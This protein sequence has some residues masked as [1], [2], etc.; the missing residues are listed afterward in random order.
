MHRNF[1][2]IIVPQQRNDN[3]LTARITVTTWDPH[4]LFTLLFVGNDIMCSG[5]S[6]PICKYLVVPNLW[7]RIQLPTDFCDN[8]EVYSTSLKLCQPWNKELKSPM[9]QFRA[10]GLFLPDIISSW[11]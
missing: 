5:I 4:Y 11:S 7:E 9:S 1:T 10:S 6:L 3:I 2:T 8:K